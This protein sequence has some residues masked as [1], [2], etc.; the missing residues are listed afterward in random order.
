[1]NPPTS[2]GAPDGAVIEKLRWYADAGRETLL[3][4]HMA[5]ARTGSVEEVLHWVDLGK[6]EFAA[7]RN[8]PA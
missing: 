8:R 3:Q 6:K 2:I 1:M 7:S 5:S 4:V